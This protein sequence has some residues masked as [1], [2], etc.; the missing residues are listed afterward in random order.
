MDFRSIRSAIALYAG[1]CVLAVVLT[2]IG[3]FYY[4]S[5]H[6]QGLVAEST[7]QLVEKAVG[8][9]LLSLARASSSEIQRSLEFPL[10]VATG[11]ADLNKQMVRAEGD[12]AVQ[13]ML[14]REALSKVVRNALMSNYQLLDAYIGWEPNAVDGRDS[15]YVGNTSSGSDA[16]GRFTPWW[17]RNESGEPMLD[18]MSSTMDSEKTLP[19][20]VREG[21][22]YLCAKETERPCV[23]DPAPYE[24][25][26]KKVMMASFTVPIMAEGKFR[27]AAGAD[28]SVEFVQEILNAANS[29]LYGGVGQMALIATNGGVVAYTQDK[30]KLGMKAGLV[31]G[32]PLVELID[33]VSE[34]RSAQHLYKSDGAYQLIYPFKIGETDSSWVLMI[35]L[36]ESA[37]LK[38]LTALQEKLAVQRKS[39][40]AG[41]AVVG[42]MVAILALIILWFVSNGVAR[43]L[44]QLVRALN[45]VTEGDGD[46]TRRLDVQRRD[47]LGEIASGLN[48]FLNKLQGIIVKVVGSVQEVS[49]S[50]LQ[51]ERIAVKTHGGIQKQLEEVDQVATAIHEMT[52]AAQEVARNA[53]RTA[54]AASMAEFA[55][56]DGMQIVQ[57]NLEA[58]SAV[59]EELEA[60]REVVQHLAR[61][62]ESIGEILTTISGIA[63]QTNLLALNAAIEAAR[64]GEQGRGFAVVADEVRSL[65]QKTQRATGEIQAM[66]NQLQAGTREAV[67]AMHKSQQCAETS[68]SQANKAAEAL[69]SIKQSVSIINDMSA[70]IASAAEEQSAVAE[71]INRSVI[72]I[73]Q[74]ASDVAE[75]A[76]QS[77][78]AS[79][80]LSRLAAKQQEVVG[81]FKV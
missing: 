43:Q 30:S 9:N 40:I 76:S 44:R 51:T 59:A 20:G 7:S 29:S 21:E 14:T 42:A 38:S 17:Y 12:G 67:V 24:M 33:S 11:L 1:C 69:R 58:I 35:R 23:V 80:V 37:V 15:E 32:E 5:E 62:G 45:D 16:N 31:F 3:F 28:L 36:P 48:N 65:A 2:L 68:V 10:H 4:A 18:S 64:A 61:S 74:A 19:N 56:G 71:D 50:S 77:S 72:N 25:N 27:G 57:D 26:G 53:G 6:G 41:M 39:G 70:Q 63:D 60:A 54:E 49:E 55:T 73:G 81:Q 78:E 66:I 22:Y 13:L 79:A 8:E 46:L 75:G 47:E 34:S 52:A